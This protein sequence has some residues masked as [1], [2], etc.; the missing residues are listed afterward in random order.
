MRRVLSTLKWNIDRLICI[1]ELKCFLRLWIANWKTKNQS[2]ASNCIWNFKWTTWTIDEIASLTR[3][4]T[5]RVN[6]L[7][8]EFYLQH[9]F[10]FLLPPPD[11]IKFP[12]ANKKMSQYST[13]CKF[14]LLLD[15]VRERFKTVPPLDIE[16]SRIYITRWVSDYQRQHALVYF[17]FTDII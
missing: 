5:S 13:T 7:E 1:H 10:L 12:S 15:S 9:F 3:V 6:S 8:S 2:E 14:H 4:S 17:V 16:I 11:V